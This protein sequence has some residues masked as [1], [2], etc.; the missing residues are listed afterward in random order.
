[1]YFIENSLQKRVRR[2]RQQK[3]NESKEKQKKNENYKKPKKTTDRNKA[4]GNL[5][6]E[7]FFKKVLQNLNVKIIFAL[8][9]DDMNKDDES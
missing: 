1:M 9:D 2:K 3:Q 7:K 8:I 4:K 6:I 5:T